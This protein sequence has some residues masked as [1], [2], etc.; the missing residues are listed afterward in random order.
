MMD[1]SENSRSWDMYTN[2]EQSCVAAS[3]HSHK[4]QPFMMDIQQSGY[5]NPHSYYDYSTSSATAQDSASDPRSS[6]DGVAK[7]LE[8]IQ[9]YFFDFLGVGAT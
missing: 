6:D 3:I 5:S 9:P 4:N 8:A 7:H 2:N 1:M